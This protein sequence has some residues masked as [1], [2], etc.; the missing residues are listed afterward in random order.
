MVWVIY[1]VE[2][3]SK[4]SGH[5][6]FGTMSN[7]GAISILSECMMIRRQLLVHHSQVVFP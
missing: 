3:V 4:K 7:L 6:D 5:S 2:D 1:V